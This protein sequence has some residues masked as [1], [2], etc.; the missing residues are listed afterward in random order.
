VHRE[1]SIAKLTAQRFDSVIQAIPAAID[2][3]RVES[4]EKKMK[5]PHLGLNLHQKL[6]PQ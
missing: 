3:T 6:Q 2:T 4:V 1:F 5:N